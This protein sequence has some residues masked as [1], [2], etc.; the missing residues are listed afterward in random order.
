MKVAIVGSGISGLMSAY[1]LRDLHDV[2]V[3]EAN[4][5]V[6]GHTHTVP[7]E[8]EG[9]RVEVDTGF[10]VFNNKNYPNFTRLLS[11]LD[12]ASQPTTM[13]FGVRIDKDN[14][15]YRGSSLNSVFAQRR[16]IA[17][18]KFLAMLSDVIKFNK[19][20]TQ[21]VESETSAVEAGTLGD[22]AAELGLS[23]QFL[24][25][26]L[27]PF[28]SAVWS[29]NP[30]SFLDFPALTYAQFMSNH[31]LLSTRV[32]KTWRTVSGGSHTYVKKICE[33]LGSRIRLNSPVAQVQRQRNG[34][35]SANIRITLINGETHE[36]DQVILACHSDHALKMLSDAT[37]NETAILS[38]IKYEDN[39]VTL[40]SDSSIMPRSRRAWASW[41]FRSFETDVA[42]VPVTYWM[43]LLQSLESPDPL[44]VTLNS[45][46]HID[47][48]KIHGR[49]VY[50]HPIFDE[51]SIGAQKLV[52][53]IQGKKN[54]WFAGAYLGYGFHEDGAASAVAVARQL[55]A[56]W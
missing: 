1:L 45:D 40:H 7:V 10:I 32:Q 28:G 37:S 38:D 31:D 29:A 4:D 56:T 52:S 54:T 36:F 41:N 53:K 42:K 12:V 33:H 24:E 46:S 22:F 49:F 34:I 15:E 3:F 44:F 39:Q 48:A 43:N 25:W 30:T 16:N 11:E 5:Y 20:A 14:I 2:T 50:S 27:A 26:F 51:R 23:K 47:E 9:S 17:N 8:F 18:P 21:L 13:S 19:A 35:S 6:G 55:G